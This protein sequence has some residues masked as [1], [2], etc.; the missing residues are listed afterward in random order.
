MHC[1]EKQILLYISQKQRVSPTVSERFLAKEQKSACF[2][3]A[4]HQV[5]L[6]DFSQSKLSVHT[7]T[8]FCKLL[9]VS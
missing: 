8:A 4:E 6:T 3:S 2:E 7:I 9:V 5:K 1:S